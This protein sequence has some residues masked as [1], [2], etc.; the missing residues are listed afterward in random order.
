MEEDIVSEGFLEFKTL[1]ILTFPLIWIFAV[2]FTEHSEREIIIRAN[3]C[4]CL[5]SSTRMEGGE[6]RGTGVLLSYNQ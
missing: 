2:A 6:L 4:L 3:F 1:N 5:Y